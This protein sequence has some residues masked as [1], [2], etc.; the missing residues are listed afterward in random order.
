MGIKFGLKSK[1]MSLMISAT[2]YNKEENMCQ[3]LLAVDGMQLKYWNA[4]RRNV[5]KFR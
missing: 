4:L 3:Y 1:R 5:R 2:V